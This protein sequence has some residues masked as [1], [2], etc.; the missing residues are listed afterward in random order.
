[1]WCARQSCYRSRWILLFRISSMVVITTETMGSASFRILLPEWPATMMMWM[2][3]R[4]ALTGFGIGL[5]GHLRSR[6]CVSEL[7]SC[8]DGCLCG[9]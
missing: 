5:I 7:R 8:V 3:C 2:A 4:I 6:R 9:D 1:M